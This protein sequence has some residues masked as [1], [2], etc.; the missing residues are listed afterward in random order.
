[1]Q[2]VG[3]PHFEATIWQLPRPRVKLYL[4]ACPNQGHRRFRRALTEICDL[5]TDPFASK[6]DDVMWAQ[7][8]PKP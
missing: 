7:E 5:G 4:D 3:S 6:L 8:N 2:D 1:M